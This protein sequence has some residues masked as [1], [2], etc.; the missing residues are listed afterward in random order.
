MIREFPTTNSSATGGAS[1]QI[2]QTGHGFVVGNVLRFDTGSSTY[3]KAL[4]DSETNSEAVGIV[5]QAISA[6]MFILTQVGWVEDITS[7]ATLVPET[8]Y[9]LSEVTPG[10]LT[11]TEPLLLNSI[12]KPLLIADSTTSGYFFNWRGVANTDPSVGYSNSFVYADL[13]TGVLTVNHNLGSKYAIPVVWDNNNKVIEPD[14]FTAVTNTQMTVDLTSYGVITGTWYISILSAGA[15]LVTPVSIVSGGTGQQT[16]VDA[17]DALYGVLP[18]AND[19]SIDI[20]KVAWDKFSILLNHSVKAG[21]LFSSPPISTY[22]LVYT[23]AGAY[24]GGVLAPNGDIHFVPY[25][26]TTGQKISSSGVVSTYTLV[27]TAAG[28]YYGGVLAPNGDIHFVPASATTGQKISSSGVV[29]TY[30][31]VY[32]AAGAYIGGVLAPNGDI[33]FVPASATKGQK[34][35]TLPSVPF[36]HAV[37]CSPW[38]NKL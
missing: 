13:T 19:S 11:A 17:Y 38:F 26:A 33:H 2:S 36:S 37:C 30:T 12:N 10:L 18:T 5:S 16:A 6:D 23:A 25:S 8:V 32:T 1:K 22:T 20:G 3:V 4:A 21:S 31:L 14:D 28:A 35:S 34:I 24:C 9:F 15:E 7:P 27:Y 29:S